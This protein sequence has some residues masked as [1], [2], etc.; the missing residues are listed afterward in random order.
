MKVDKDGITVLPDG[1]AF[2]TASFPLPK[3]HW[4]Y[5]ET[6]EYE[7][8]PMPF[9]R[10]TDDSERKDWEA[11][12]RAAGRY[13][14]RSATMN[15][16]EKDFDPDA[17]VQNLVVAMLGY[18]T[19]DGLSKDGWANPAPVPEV[20]NATHKCSA[21]AGVG[22]VATVDCYENP[23]EVVTHRC[24]NCMGSGIAGFIKVKFDVGPS[25]G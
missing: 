2:C 1:S 10:G 22:S 13:A 16:K 3:D 15:G 6:D 4:L 8:P 24:A 9:R 21:C 19:P 11:K 18:H 12:V 23:G 14:V 17:L 25:G 7:P 5:A 20:A